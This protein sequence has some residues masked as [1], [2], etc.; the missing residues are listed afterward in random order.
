MASLC[1]RSNKTVAQS[2]YF[3]E[4]IITK[5][6]HVVIKHRRKIHYKIDKQ[7]LGNTVPIFQIS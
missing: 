1:N 3:R 4:S 5:N 7:F 6:L 2:D